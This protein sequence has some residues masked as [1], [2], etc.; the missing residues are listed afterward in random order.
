MTRYFYPHAMPHLTMPYRRRRR[1]TAFHPQHVE[2][3]SD[4]PILAPEEKNMLKH[5]LCFDG[6][7]MLQ[8][9]E[10]VA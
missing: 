8:Q 9:E 1:K 2:T 4:L 7:L 3:I 5:L 10:K 6:D